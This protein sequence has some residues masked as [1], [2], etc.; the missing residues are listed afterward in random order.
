[1]LYI[2]P[3]DGSCNDVRTFKI[4]TW[5]KLFGSEK[6]YE[7]KGLG[8]VVSFVEPCWAITLPAPTHEAQ[9]EELPP[10]EMQV[11][12]PPTVEVQIVEPPTQES[13]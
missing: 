6:V 12:A 10:V 13:P 9:V 5:V 3:E 1:V 4:R 11:V 7:S 8:T 2:V